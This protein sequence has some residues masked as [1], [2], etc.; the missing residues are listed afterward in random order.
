MARGLSYGASGIART[1]TG[2][3]RQSADSVRPVD[4]DRPFP[5]PG[6]LI[7]RRVT[8]YERFVKP[9]IDRV[10][11][12]VLLVLFVPVFAI[13]AAAVW[14]SVRRP[15]VLRQTRVGRDE[16]LFALHKF[17]TMRPDRRHNPLDYTGRERRQ[18]HKH[19]NDPRLTRVGRKLRK[20]S[21][22][23][24]PQLWDV[25]TGKLSLVGPRP[26]LVNIVEH[27]EAWQHGRHAVKPGLTGLWQITAR[28]NG[29][30]MHEHTEL[31]ID[32]AQ[33]VTFGRDLKI[34]A[35][36]IPALITHKGY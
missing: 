28:G 16:K 32:Y 30:E 31:D 29:Q 36:T 10:L 9:V 18:T 11:A 6:A 35:L 23:E 12:C 5:P 7:L 27:Y 33:R 1:V 22:D 24:L 17:R 8:R 34:M 19:P 26:E 21:L 15:I 13:V 25:L 20:W 2:S 14:L 3:A 4:G